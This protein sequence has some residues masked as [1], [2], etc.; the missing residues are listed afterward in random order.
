MHFGGLVE[1][2]ALGKVKNKSKE[3]GL[4]VEGEEKS[5]EYRRRREDG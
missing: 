4:L 5:V 2:K 1:K 3:G